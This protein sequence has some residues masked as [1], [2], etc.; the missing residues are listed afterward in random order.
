M[1]D[2]WDEVRVRIDAADVDALADLLAGLGDGDRTALVPHLDGH[3][4]AL[5]EPEPVVLPPLEP[6]PLPDLPTSGFITV[7]FVAYDKELPS[8]LQGVREMM[9]RQRTRQR[10]HERAWQRRRLEEDARWAAS[11][12]NDSRRA[13][14][15]FALVACTLKAPDAVKL[16]HRPWSVGPA[17]QVSPEVV[18]ALL[19]VRGSAWC[20]T[21]ARGLLRRTRPRTQGV[22]WAFTEA[23]L[24]S[25]DADVPDTPAAAA[26][27]VALDR[28]HPLAPLLAADPWLDHMLS[29][30]L[31]DD[32]GVANAF[33][34]GAAARAW[35][36]ALLELAGSA[37]VDRG[38]LVAGC[39]RRLRAGGRKG[40]LQSYL[41]LVR[42]LAPTAEESAGHTQELIG[43]LTAPMSTVADFAYTCLQAVHRSA[44]L[45]PLSLAEITQNMLCRPEKKLVRA[46]LAWL[47]PMPLD[48]LVEGLVVGLHHPVPELAER[49]LDLVETRL[50]G[51][52]E[53]AR[54]RLAAEVPALDGTVGNRLAAALGT[55]APA[56]VPAPVLA[57]AELPREMPSPL[58][59]GAL[60]GELSVLLRN[61]DTDPVRHEAVLDGLVRAANG[62]RDLAARVLEP[63]I[64]HWYGYWPALIAA[65]F[66]RSVGSPGRQ[67]PREH[68]PLSL[69]VNGRLAELRPRLIHQP[70]PGLLATPATVAGHVDPARVLNLL[71][72][73]DRDRWQPAAG[74]LTQALL[75]LPREVEPA[76]H[77]AAARLSSPAG[78]RFAAWLAD[79]V[80]DA[81]TWIEEVDETT[82]DRSRR[83]AMLDLAGLPA[84][85]GDARTA[86]ERSASAWH[87]PSLALWPMIT[88]SHREIAAAHLQPVVALAVDH[89]NP[90]TGFLDGL[91]AADGPAGPA[92]ALTMV[93]AL[94]NRREGVRLAAGDALST[95]A[96]RPG[97]DS[98]GIGV[99]LGI[100]AGSDRI[101]LQRT[102]QPLTEALKA[103]AHDAV[104]QIAS[105]ALPDLLAAKPRPGL[106]E[107]LTLAADAARLGRHTGQEP[108]GLAA[109]T[110]RPGRSQLATAARK[111]AEALR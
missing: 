111:L 49:T 53:K 22:R 33:S 102:L 67:I 106:P 32:D 104:W 100:L 35:P 34:S 29:T 73:A 108:P 68:A 21:L 76:V 27:Y 45:D 60:A 94:A 95:F 14:T 103:G 7:G 86:A 54:E 20:T 96:A 80:T 66:G 58:D 89:Q 5:A 75:R 4:P 17:P 52:S 64:T 79:G 40:V 110:G 51:L 91:A 83:I 71:Q 10:E 70:P 109:I 98:T 3:I 56:V 15:G 93:Y 59:L 37:R 39:L 43:L 24:R 57:A 25:V 6:E 85:I 42:D 1:S 92:T 23:L 105:A 61:G 9:A 19:R 41:G 69:F 12:L 31:F 16:L 62:D 81:R 2:L 72:Q 97:W 50:A 44:G 65:T 90:G 77:A 82:Y 63:L 47:R 26:Q 87:M 38:L 74:D 11:R 8:D 55:A 46:H 84:E 88:P 36:A 78:R 101:V 13:A 28:G 48:D 18:P 107:L 30:Y 99:E